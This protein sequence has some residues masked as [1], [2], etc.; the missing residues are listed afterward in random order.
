MSIDEST[1]IAYD[2]PPDLIVPDT[3]QGTLQGVQELMP[4][5]VKRGT[6]IGL[7]LLV[8]YL[9]VKIICVG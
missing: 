1:P 4:T 8:T 3:Y 5:L 9:A 7:L 2:L 6:I